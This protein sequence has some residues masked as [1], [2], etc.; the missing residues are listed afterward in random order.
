MSSSNDAVIE[1]PLEM[2]IYE[3][4]ITQLEVTVRM[5]RLAASSWADSFLRAER[6]QRQVDA[7]LAERDAIPKE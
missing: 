3:A 2:V 5:G 4:W 6:L 7:L 1:K